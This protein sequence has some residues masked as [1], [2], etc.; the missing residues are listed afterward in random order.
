MGRSVH[1]LPLLRSIA[2]SSNLFIADTGS[3]T[4]RKLVLA[5]G[6]VST[7]AGG[8]A[9]EG[10]ADGVGQDARF[11]R[12]SGIVYDGAGCLIVSDT[13]NDVIRKVVLATGEVSTLAGRPQYGGNSDGTE[14]AQF[15]MPTGIALDGAGRLYVADAGNHGIRRLVLA[16][17][18]VS[19]LAGASGSPGSADGIGSEARFNWPTGIVGDGAEL[20]AKTF[21]RK[22]YATASV[23]KSWRN[24][25]CGKAGLVPAALVAS[26]RPVCGETLRPCLAPGRRQLR[27]Q[28]DRRAE[29]HLVRR[30]AG[31]AECG[32]WVL[33]SSTNYAEHRIMPS[34]ETTPD[35]E[36]PVELGIIRARGGRPTRRRWAGSA[37]A[38]HP[39]VRCGRAHVPWW[40]GRRPRGSVARGH[41]HTSGVHSCREKLRSAEPFLRSQ[42][43]TLNERGEAHA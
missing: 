34:R 3:H 31:D 10:Y 18:E 4:I 19:T 5:T 38:W 17:G 13:Y 40:R 32:I 27:R 35:E 2:A 37:R 36:L 41:R 39:W 26:H 7:L 30:L 9:D 42:I 14:G 29:V 21:R 43:V 15:Q 25:R 33:C 8:P 22:A 11:Y 16:T 28:V 23:L 20:C 6:A 12:P 24:W 1:R